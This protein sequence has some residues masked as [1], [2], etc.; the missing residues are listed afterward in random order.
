VARQVAIIT[1]GSGRRAQERGRWTLGDRR[2][3][4]RAGL[5]LVLANVRYWRTVAPIV[6][7]QL[8]HWEQRAGAIDD[9]E[10]RALALE[11]LRDES[12]HAEAAA[13]LA[14]LAPREHRRDVVEAIVALELLFDYLDGLTEL[15]T[16]DPLGDRAL[17]F[18]AYRDALAPHPPGAGE[19][20]D[21]HDGDYLQG[22]SDTVSDR[23]QRLPAACAIAPLALENAALGAQTQVRMHTVAELGV[24]Q[25]EDWARSA[26]DGTGLPWRELLAAAASSVLVIHALIAAA[27]DPGTTGVQAAEIET[28]YLSTCVLLT[29]LDGLVDHDEDTRAANASGAAA[30]LGYLGLYE[31]RR[32]ELSQTL[33]GAARRAAMQARALP[34]GP[35]HLMVLV[36]VVAYYTSAPGANSELAAPIVKPLQRQLAPL[37]F[38]TLALM[39]A[40]RLAKRV[41]ADGKLPAIA[42]G[43]RASIISRAITREWRV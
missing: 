13:M 41:R 34:N 20:A 21:R 5:A 6:R 36:G 39:R 31:D 40:W 23:L 26:A 22:L 32:E 4:A 16:A 14:T 3:V 12:F 7:G 33:T 8:R 2:L 17:L 18:N 42:G 15:P 38:P 24:G 11:K 28:A 1:D 27:A 9:P 19:L 10:L 37:I 43:R 29:L 25:L 35:H 30:G